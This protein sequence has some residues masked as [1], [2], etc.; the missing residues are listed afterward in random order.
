MNLR[1]V[2]LFGLLLAVV[3]VGVSG[4]AQPAPSAKRA[5]EKMAADIAAGKKITPD[6]LKK[7]FDTWQDLKEMMQV[8]KPGNNRDKGL[9]DTLIR[10]S[11]QETFS[12]ADKATLQRISRLSQAMGLITYFYTQPVQDDVTRLTDWRT[13]STGLGQGGG[14]LIEAI[15]KG[16]GKSI[17]RA[18][19]NLAATCTDCHG[20]WRV[21]FPP[22]PKGGPADPTLLPADKGKSKSMGKGKGKR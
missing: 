3:V 17:S 14:E 16:N 21:W 4:H 19:I 20:A 11:A 8:Y 9:E 13:Y 2:G 22:P 7:F 1:H 12:A 5:V 10:L 18:A 6:D 15:K